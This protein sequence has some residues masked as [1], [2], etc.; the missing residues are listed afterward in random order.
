MKI[1]KT[2]KINFANVKNFDDFYDVMSELFGLP[3]FFGRNGHALV[4]CLLYLREPEAG[5]SRI[6]IKNNEYLLLKLINFS[7]LN[8][9]LKEH[10]I[11]IFEYLSLKCNEIGEEVPIV[12]SLN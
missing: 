6:H 4:D 2:L 9:E 3:D 12:L 1:E 11:S 5:M 8:K 7:S 10:F